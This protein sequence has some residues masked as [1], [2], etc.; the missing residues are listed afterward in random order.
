MKVYA[1]LPPS[2]EAEGSLW[3]IDNSRLI[4]GPVRC[5]GEAD[6]SGAQKANNVQ[7]D[8]ATSYGDHPYGVSRV[9]RVIHDPKPRDSYGPA[10]ISLAPVS[11]QAWQA[12]LNGRTGIGIHGGKLGANDILR[13]TYGCLRMADDDLVRLIE[14]IEPQIASGEV[15][16]ECCE[17][18][19]TLR[20]EEA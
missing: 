4:F 3:V 7:E 17:Q 8:P 13:V 10:F 6:N 16:Y 18:H 9:Q 14:L 19:A 12:R 2:R 5:R 11:G 20:T 1:T 15:Y